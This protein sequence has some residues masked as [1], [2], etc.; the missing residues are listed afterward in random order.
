MPLVAKRGDAGDAIA[1]EAARLEWLA[2]TGVSCP[3][4]VAYHTARRATWLVMTRLPGSDLTAAG[5][6]PAQT[7]AIAAAALQT[8]HALDPSTCPFDARTAVRLAQARARTAAGLIDPEDF[9]DERQDISPYALLAQLDRMRPATE[10][11]VVT[12]GDACLDNLIVADGG[13]AGFIDVGR[14]GVADRHQDLAL[15]VRDISS[16]Y[17]KDW[18]ERFLAAYGGTVDRAKLEFYKVLDEFF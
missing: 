14:L 2:T 9:D 6:P 16:D 1:D 18:G 10:D 8:L 4:V 13:F 15:A 11:L 7:V 3:R 12:H 5:L 17:G